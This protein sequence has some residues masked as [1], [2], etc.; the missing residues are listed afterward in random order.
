[1]WTNKL[2]H[3]NNLSHLLTW[4]FFFTNHRA[5]EGN[6]AFVSYSHSIFL[7]LF[8]SAFFL[9]I[10]SPVPFVLLVE[11]SLTT[12]GNSCCCKEASQEKPEGKGGEL[13]VRNGAWG[14]SARRVKPLLCAGLRWAFPCKSQSWATAPIQGMCQ[15][16]RKWQNWP[17]GWS[18]GHWDVAQKAVKQT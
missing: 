9:E 17:Q 8:F 7:N 11:G 15:Q 2:L 6:R 3:V 10:R 13:W 5:P 12:N 1:M 4:W 16:I 14:L 18:Q